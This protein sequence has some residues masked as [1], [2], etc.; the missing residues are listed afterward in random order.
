MNSEVPVDPGRDVAEAQLPAQGPCEVE[1]VLLQ[2][3]VVLNTNINK[4]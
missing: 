2:E 1:A 3:V 4:G